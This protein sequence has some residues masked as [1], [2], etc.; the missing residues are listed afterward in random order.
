MWPRPAYCSYDDAG[1]NLALRHVSDA[2]F[3]LTEVFVYRSRCSGRRRDIPLGQGCVQNGW[4][5]PRCSSSNGGM[6]SARLCSSP[7]TKQTSAVVDGE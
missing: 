6:A 3:E 2:T 1:P 5:P 7:D 4:R